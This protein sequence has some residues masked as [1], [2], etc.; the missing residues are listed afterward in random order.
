MATVPTV[1]GRTVA[2][3]PITSPLQRAPSD[4]GGQAL[5]QGFIKAGDSLRRADA[6]ISA[7]T[8]SEADAAFIE[9]SNKRLYL[10]DDAYFKRQGKD[11]VDGLGGATAELDEIRDQVAEEFLTSATENQIFAA[12]ANKRSQLAKVK[13]GAHSFDERQ[14]WDRAVSVANM[15]QQLESAANDPSESNLELVAVRLAEEVKNVAKIDG[16]PPEAQ[17][18]A[19]DTALSAMYRAAIE[20]ALITDLNYA[21]SLLDSF[22][23]AIIATD[24]TAIRAK[25]KEHTVRVRGAGIADDVIRD[26]GTLDQQLAAAR[27][28]AGKNIEVRDDAVRRVT[29]RFNQDNANREAV[30]RDTYEALGNDVLNGTSVDS[31]RNSVPDA[32]DILKQNQKEHLLKLEAERDNP[33]ATNWARWSELSLMNPRELALIDPI[34][35]RLN[36]ADTEFRNLVTMVDEARSGDPGFA[37]TSIQTPNAKMIA[38]LGGAKKARKPKGQMAFAEFTER[39]EAFEQLKTGKA[40]PTEINNIIADLMVEVELP[41]TF[42]ASPFNRLGNLTSGLFGGRDRQVF[43]IQLQ[44][45]PE[46]DQRGIESAYRRLK[47]RDPTEN[48]IIDAFAK[49]LQNNAE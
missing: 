47:G 23:D 20:S 1:S 34:D 32:W 33:N 27:K 6:Q 42:S 3:R 25:L 31:I 14:K 16:A 10:D 39:L 30:N 24:E 41:A 8:L 49:K 4:A 9:R 44:D 28:K 43:Q 15:Q 2:P 17:Q 7:I 38:A 37:F 29:N 18:V 19:I 46:R 35:E 5:A 26:G 11:A 21:E 45:V 48:E 22:K 12:N 13:M 40:T 36:L